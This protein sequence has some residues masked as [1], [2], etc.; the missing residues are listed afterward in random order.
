M[1][2]N[3]Q[4]MPFNRWWF[5]IPFTEVY[6]A[7]KHQKF[8]SH[9]VLQQGKIFSLVETVGHVMMHD[10]PSLTFFGSNRGQDRGGVVEREDPFMQLLQANKARMNG[11][12][13]MGVQLQL[14]GAFV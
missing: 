5:D 8:M 2:L 6:I 3:Q 11:K 7:R 14:P 13:M 9:H 1:G 4:C 10:C 12:D